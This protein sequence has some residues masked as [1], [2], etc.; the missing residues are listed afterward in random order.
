MT[1]YSPKN[2]T[3]YTAAYAG[4][5]AGIAA[6]QRTPTDEVAT[7]PPLVGNS[8]IA[9]AWAQELDTQW[10]AAAPSTLDVIAIEECSAAVFIGSS[11]PIEAPF[12]TPSNWS[13][14][15]SSVIA[16][17]KA[18]ENYFAGQG[19]TPDAWPSGNGGTGTT[20]ATGATGSTGATGPGSGTTGA[21]GATGATGSTGPTGATGSG[22]TGPTGPT[23][24]LGGTA[25][26]DLTGTYPNPSVKSISSGVGGVVPIEDPIQVN[27]SLGTPAASGAI[28]LPQN[29]SINA[30]NAANNADLD[31]LAT[32][33]ADDLVL[34]SPD[35]PVTTVDGAAVTLG[36]HAI[37]VNVPGT[38]SVFDAAGPVASEGAIRLAAS[39]TIKSRNNAGTADVPMLA[40]D[41]SD[42]VLLGSSAGTSGAGLDI[43][44]NAGPITIGNFASTV[45]VSAP[46]TLGIT[47]GATGSRPTSPLPFQ[48]FFDTT[49]HYLVTWDGTNWRN[50]AGAIV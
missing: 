46:T 2:K 15:V 10:G 45:T 8:D 6:S 37:P 42:K 33:G 12:A 38:L 49:L 39:P 26:G 43:E 29:A 34:G 47:G 20:G 50:G 24:A 5:I 41:A 40:V 27:T 25:G 3:T 19:I 7:D 44:T 1:T 32:D 11:P 28:R 31:L 9:G 35:N 14:P 16:I 4:A 21:T 22:A 48:S 30:R 17:V 36:S 13:A 23:G 18:S